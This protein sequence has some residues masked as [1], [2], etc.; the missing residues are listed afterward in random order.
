M[1]LSRFC[2]VGTGTSVGA[3]AKLK[4]DFSG[5]RSV[6]MEKKLFHNRRFTRNFAIL[7]CRLLPQLVEQIQ[8]CLEPDKCSRHFT[9][10][11]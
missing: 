8:F 7:G 11:A 4:S 10:K 9:K 2:L 1:W 5:R 3:F 6:H